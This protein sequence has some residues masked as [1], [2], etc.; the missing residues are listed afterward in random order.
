[1]YADELLLPWLRSPVAP[2]PDVSLFDAHTH[3]G[4]NDPD[5][6]TC[7]SEELIESLRLVEARAVVFPLMERAG[8]RKVR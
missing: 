3:L 2:V 5:G 4:A 1:M 6:W 7:S 8:Y